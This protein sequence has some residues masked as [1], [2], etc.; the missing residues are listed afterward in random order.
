MKIVRGF[1]EI[2]RRRGT[3]MADDKST[4]EDDMSDADVELERTVMRERAERVHR[5]LERNLSLPLS[6][7][8]QKSADSPPAAEDAPR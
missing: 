4:V 6:E 1:C 8:P 5:R 2:N 3:E 7:K